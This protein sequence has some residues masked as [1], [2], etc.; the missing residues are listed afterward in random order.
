ME[1]RPLLFF[2]TPD[3][4]SRSDLPRGGASVSR[5]SAG[6]QWNKLEPRFQ[7]LQDAFNEQRVHLQQTA[8]GIEPEQ[9]LV[10]ETI[11]SIQDFANA[12]KKVPGMEWMGQ[13]E[14]DSVAPD[15]DFYDKQ[16]PDKK[17]EAQLYLVMSNQ[18][19]LDG[20]LSLWARYKENP[21]FQFGY[22]LTKFRDVFLYLKDIRR[23]GIRERLLETGLLE[24]WEEDL[25]H[26]P[27]RPVRFEAELWFRRSYD[28]RASRGEQVARLINQ[29]GGRV[30]SQAVIEEISYHAILGELPASA[31]QTIRDSHSTQLVQCESVMFFRPVGQMSVGMA[32][33]EEETIPADKP[34]SPIPTGDPIIALLDGMPL[35]NHQLLKGRLEIDD[36]DD[37]GMEYTASERLHGT[38]MASLIVHGDLSAP[39]SPLQRPIYV[40]PIMKPIPWYSQPRPEQM[41]SDQLA[42]DLIHRAV[43]R[44]FEGEGNEPPAAPQVKIINLSIG[45]ERRPFLRTMS[46][47]ARLLDWLSAKYSVLFIVSAG[48]HASPIVFDPFLR[49]IDSLSSD[50]LE[51]AVVLSLYRD[52]RNRRLLSPAEAINPITVGAAHHDSSPAAPLAPSRINPLFSTLPSPVSA[53]GSGYLRSVKPDVLY[54][55]GRQ[56]YQRPLTTTSPQSISLARFIT[57]PGNKFAFPS[58]RPGDVTATAYGCGTSNAT[59]L[60]CR[61]AGICYEMLVAVLSS[62]PEER[63]LQAYEVPLL[64]ALLVHGCSWEE[65]GVRIADILRTPNNGKQLKR[66]AGNWLGYGIPDVAKVLECTEQ[67]ATLLGFGDLSDGQ[68]HIFKLPLPPSLGSRR[69]WRRITATL[70]WLSPIA[71]NTQKYRTAGLWF[72]IKGASPATNRQDACSGQGGWRFV[73]RG[74]VQHEIFEGDKAEPITDGDTI[75]IKVNCR[76]DAGKITVPVAYGLAVTIEVAEGVN[77]PIYDEIRTRISPVIQIRQAQA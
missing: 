3:T 60:M 49:S 42:V 65:M 12:V 37:F 22:G 25:R 70:A 35:S 11:G 71:A 32:N 68:A 62:Y 30:V 74:T 73:R 77:I 50:E 33:M 47:L 51:R 7:Q 36:P 6:K 1:E 29:L 57:P 40:R 41:P 66:L 52:A 21:Q 55:G 17:L 59:A 56:C 13:V 44:L 23:W 4:A 72:E 24:A 16:D 2:P 14:S 53:F 20:M 26:D 54:A 61:S 39:S 19:A 58:S 75:N 46:P 15:E 27:N 8:A 28:Q 48:N 34:D 31:V 10:I 69:D 64:K 5:A 63:D 9:V 76:K 18:K 45:D 43:R 38:S 67:R